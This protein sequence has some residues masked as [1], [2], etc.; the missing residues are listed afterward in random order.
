VGKEAESRRRVCPL[1][2]GRYSVARRALMQVAFWLALIILAMTGAIYL[3]TVHTQTEQSVTELLEYSQQRGK[4]ES[5]LFQLAQVSNETVIS[6][7]QDQWKVLPRDEDPAPRFD[8][9]HQQ[10]P[11]GTFRIRPSLID[12]KHTLSGYFNKFHPPTPVM[13]KQALL[14]RD[15]VS[16][17]GPIYS[18][19][20]LNLYIFSL[21]GFFYAY[22]P[23]KPI[24]MTRDAS[25]DARV[26]RYP[27]NYLNA[28]HHFWMEPYADAMTGDL[29]VS[30]MTPFNLDGKAYGLVGTDLS[31]TEMM[32]RTD[33]SNLPGAHNL[34]VTQQGQ[35]VS[36]PRHAKDLAALLAVNKKGK[37]MLKDSAIPEAREILET[38]PKIGNS[39]VVLPSS[40]GQAYLACTP[41]KGPGWIFVTVYP[42]SLITSAAF[43]SAKVVLFLG[44]IALLLEMV[45]LWII[46]RRHVGKPLLELAATTDKFAAGDMSARLQSNRQDELGHLSSSFDAMA[47]AVQARDRALADQASQLEIALGEAE[48]AREAAERALEHRSEFLANMSHEIRTPLN[49]VLGMVELL[50]DT[51]LDVEQRDYVETLRE[52]GSGLLTILNDILDLSKLEAGKMQ[53]Q[54]VEFDIAEI[55]RRVVNLHSP[56][57]A[58]KGLTLQ[59]KSDLATG[60]V[61]LADAHRTAQVLGNL[62]SNAIKF[63]SSGSVTVRAHRIGDKFVR[64]EVVDTG[65]GIPV[66]RQAA[67]FGAFTQADGSLARSYGGTGLGL[68]IAKQFVDL[69]GG[70]IGLQS[71]PGDGTTFW[72]DLPFVN[73]L[74]MNAA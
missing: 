16:Q 52:S 32:A 5:D 56:N 12:P 1:K 73:M 26:T 71:D 35:L 38:L 24:G 30:C 62:L 61:V 51:K 60:E 28:G 66:E 29:M 67:V 17:F 59:W 45:V 65:I 27:E 49:G 58:K 37:M 23:G 11:D 53:L 68:T 41:L 8:G 50:F 43:D 54:I 74:G 18:S 64:V 14:T 31:L 19:R 36:D 57:A 69:M 15:I 21:D 47:D 40:D 25:T 7:F 20:F 22:W 9:I 72:V 10:Y 46:L 70:N 6:E 55:M 4:R 42:R 63:T 13:K 34:I 33:R 2:Y 48:L 39:T 44:G 3:R